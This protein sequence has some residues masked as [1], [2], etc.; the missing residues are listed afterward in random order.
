MINFLKMFLGV[1]LYSR[2]GIHKSTFYSSAVLCIGTGEKS[3]LEKEGDYDPCV[4]LYGLAKAGQP[5]L[6]R[7][8]F[9]SSAYLTSPRLFGSGRL[10]SSLSKTFA[11]CESR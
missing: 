6:K 7:D 1:K 2:L 11:Q 9:L 10:S 3:H 4:S 5:R 8:I